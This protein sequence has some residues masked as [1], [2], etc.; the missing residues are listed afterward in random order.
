M[1]KS[2]YEFLSRYRD[3]DLPPDSSLSSKEQLIF[4]TC[5][6]DRLIRRHYNSQGNIVYTLSPDGISALLNFEHQLEQNAEEQARH[7]IERRS[8]REQ[9]VE[10]RKADRRHDFK[11]VI[12]SALIAAFLDLINNLISAHL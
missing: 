10:D 5:K 8:D 3:A 9:T 2:Q 7:E 6:A 11:I 4:K 12:L 1:T